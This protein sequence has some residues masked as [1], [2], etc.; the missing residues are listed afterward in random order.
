MT[1][2]LRPTWQMTDEELI[3]QADALERADDRDA[4]TDP[5]TLLHHLIPTYKR[6]PHIRIIGREFARLQDGDG[7]RLM[8]LTPPQVGKSLTAA[9]GGPL[10]WL[11]RRPTNRVIVAS[12]GN[13]LAVTRGR[14]VRKLIIEHGHRYNLR[15]EPGSQAANDWSLTTGGG[16]KSVGVGAG[17]AGSPGDIAIIDDP[18]KSRAEA[19]SLR[20]R[21]KVYDWYSADIL[22]RL[23]PGSPVVLIMT[24]WHPDD[25][26]ARVLA[27]EGTVEE[28]GRWRVV[29]M[30]ALCTDPERDPLGRAEG[31]PLPHPKIKAG[32]T[33]A[34]LKHWQDK[35]R[36]STLRD[37]FALYQGDPQPAEGALLTR[38][39]LREQRC[40][41][42]QPICGPCNTTVRK[43]AVA[44][45][46]SGGGRD[47]AGI[48]GGYLGEDLRLYLTHDWSGVMPSDQWARKACELAATIDADV[49]VYETTFGGDMVLLSIRTAW[50][51]LRHE[52][53]E[54]LGGNPD[55][56]TYKLTAKYNRISPRVKGV[57]ARKNKLLRAE[58]IAQQWLEDRIRTAAY[59]PETEEE[60]ATWQ[61]DHKDSPGRIDA[62]V[63]LAYELLPM[64]PAGQG[65]VGPPPTGP[66]PTTGISPLHNTEG[67]GRAGFGALG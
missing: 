32:D 35:R 66:M 63:Y 25:L 57:H 38:A 44:V 30:P 19:D 53:L 24:P 62:S 46:P 59:L 52:E 5:A 21:D 9:V 58:P 31:A 26:R 3:A 47:T 60:W 20:I 64:P 10:W 8:I 14:S 13:S 33:E 11:A 56:D 36:S 18:H 61:P 50:N 65:L 40:Y 17:V 55:D 49:I 16:M 48:I 2:A 29:H 37:W 4:L 12:Y 67:T 51:A 42:H 43:A 34:A 23:S 15:M 6:R 54:R 7:Q 45:D 28:G 27:D 1:V 41:G 39:K 22:S